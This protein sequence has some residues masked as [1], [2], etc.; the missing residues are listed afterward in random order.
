MRKTLIIICVVLINFS[1]NKNGDKADAYGNFESV[2]TTISAESGGKLINFEIEEGDIIEKG[3]TVGIIDTTSLYL[4]KMQIIAQKNAISSKSSNVMS[5][6][7][8]IE[9]QK[10][11][12]ETERKRLIKLLADSAAT[13]RQMDEVEGKINVL[14]RQIEQ[15]MTQNRSIFDELKIFD[16]Q[17]NIINNQI[18]K[19]Y[20]KNPYKASVVVKYSEKYEIAVPGKPLYKIADLS[21]MNLK[22]YISETQLNSIQIGQEVEIAIDD[23]LEEMHKFKGK[24]LRISD[25]A[26]FTPKTIQTKE[27]RVNLVY[28]VTISVKNDGK[29]KIGMPAEVYFLNNKK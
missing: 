23:E 8:V 4:Q 29:L 15:V 16:A 12:V 19:C 24:V 1:C 22:A 2:T 6:I 28:A 14:N 26:E 11:S 25:K 7:K 3:I 10:A 17:L 20:I 18:E 21:E 5:Q 9:E 13:Q 27:E